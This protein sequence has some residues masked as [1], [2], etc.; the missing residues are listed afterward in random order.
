MITP[1]WSSRSWSFL[2]SSFVYSCHPFFFFFFPF[3]FFISTTFFLPTHLDL[4]LHAHMLSFV[5]PWSSARQTPLSMEFSRQEYWSELPFLSPPPPLLTSFD[6]V[7]SIPFLFFILP[8]FAGNISFVSLS[9]LKRSLVFLI[10]LFSSI[11]FAL[12]T[13]ESFLISPCYSLEI[14]IQM[15]VFFLFSFALNVRLP[16]L[17]PWQA[18]RT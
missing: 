10:R 1:S 11:F 13:E 9:F 18:A 3:L 17:T 6:F 12:I 4:H 14:W 7:K 8:I 16:G 5:I 2:N 15:G